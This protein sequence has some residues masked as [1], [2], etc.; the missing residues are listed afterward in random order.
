MRLS[1]LVLPLALAACVPT[2]TSVV[3]APVRVV[4]KTVDVLT[5]SPSEKD[6]HYAHRLRKQHEREVRERKAM[7]KRCRG[8][9]STAECQHYGG[10]G[11]ADAAR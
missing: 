9:E 10:D 3:T 7:A 8:H 5:V 4:G 1:L 6:R 2:V 11:A